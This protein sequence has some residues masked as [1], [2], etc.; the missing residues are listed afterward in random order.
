MRVSRNEPTLW[1]VMGESFRVERR[2]MSRLWRLIAKDPSPEAQAL[3]A[4]LQQVTYMSGFN[5]DSLRTAFRRWCASTGR[6]ERLLTLVEKYVQA[7]DLPRREVVQ[8]E[9]QVLSHTEKAL[10]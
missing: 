4:E 1:T 3:R 9:E 6:P 10:T 8:F 5:Y 7:G 2:R